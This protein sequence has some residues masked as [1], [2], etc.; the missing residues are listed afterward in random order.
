MMHLLLHRINSV[1]A[2]TAA[3]VAATVGAAKCC[4]NMHVECI[5]RHKS[6]DSLSALRFECLD[7]T[8]DACCKQ[9]FAAFEYK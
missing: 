3:V 5:I 9:H 4:C 1:A 6:D 2:A 8:A 7:S